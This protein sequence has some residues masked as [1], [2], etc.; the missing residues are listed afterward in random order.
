MV[1][2]EVAALLPTLVALGP[3]AQ[4]PGAVSALVG[5]HVVLLCSSGG[6]VPV[7]LDPACHPQQDGSSAQGS[8]WSCRSLGSGDR[9][10][11]PALRSLLGG[12][13]ALG[14]G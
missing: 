1:V 10:Q 14:V 4:R 2:M 3:W 6:A 7:G 13:P 9:E 11:H 12:I 5:D 8:A